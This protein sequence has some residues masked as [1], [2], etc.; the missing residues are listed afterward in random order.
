[1]NMN[2]RDELKDVDGWEE[3]CDEG[4]KSVETVS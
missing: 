1:M 4:D 2:M 3:E